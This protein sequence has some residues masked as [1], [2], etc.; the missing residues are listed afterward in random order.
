M[1]HSHIAAGTVPANYQCSQCSATSCK[2]YR[3]DNRSLVELFCRDCVELLPVATKLAIDFD[4]EGNEL[5]PAPDNVA[6]LKNSAGKTTLLFIPAI[7]DFKK[8]WYSYPDVPVIGLDWWMA[9]PH[10]P[11]PL[12]PFER[13]IYASNL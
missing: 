13:G 2:L 8:G 1:F 4:E 5:Y 6:E 12:K 3:L 11:T 7:P 9:L 10:L